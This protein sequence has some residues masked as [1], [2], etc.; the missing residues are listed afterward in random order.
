MEAVAIGRR[1]PDP[2]DDE[3]RRRRRSAGRQQARGLLQGPADRAL[4]MDHRALLTLM[5]H[6]HPG[7]A[8]STVPQEHAGICRH[9][10]V[11]RAC[12]LGHRQ[13]GQ[14]KLKGEGEDGAEAPE[15]AQ[16]AGSCP[17]PGHAQ[18]LPPLTHG[19][20]PNGKGPLLYRF[21]DAAHQAQFFCIP[22]TSFGR[23]FL[24]MST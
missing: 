8:E 6:R 5:G 16:E 9:R 4:M 15:L 1:G 20:R 17:L 12:R 22:V 11:L 3:R 21:R 14:E 2:G 10:H 7:L 23:L 18:M 13:E 24:N 19:N